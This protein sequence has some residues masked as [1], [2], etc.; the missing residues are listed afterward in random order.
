HYLDL[1]EGLDP[2]YGSSTYEKVNE[3][4]GKLYDGSLK[5]KSGETFA[6]WRGRFMS[7][8]N[9]LKAE[10]DDMI[11]HAR[12]FMRAGLASGT[13]VA[14]YRG[15]T[16]IEFLDRARDLDMA[17]RQIDVGRSKTTAA[18]PSARKSSFRPEGTSAQPRPSTTS[19]FAEKK[20]TFS[21]TP[22]ERRLLAANR[23]CFRCG[24]KD[25]QARDNK[26]R[27]A[28]SFDKIK[29]TYNLSVIS[30]QEAEYDDAPSAP[31]ASNDSDTTKDAPLAEDECRAQ[32][33]EWRDACDTARRTE[34]RF[35]RLESAAMRIN[36]P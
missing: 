36:A 14:S 22:E 21:R 33:L 20:V 13:S 12:Q 31:S 35:R 30:A 26:C 23:L 8:R 4:R 15:E 1:L 5:Q 17:H 34:R 28:K 11:A 16:L 9:I 25:H 7:V 10:D 24:S 6:S 18:V 27:E 3:A 29:A 32:E 19:R 2:Y